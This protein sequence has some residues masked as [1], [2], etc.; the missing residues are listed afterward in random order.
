MIV[1]LKKIEARD[2]DPRKPAQ[3]RGGFSLSAWLRR[4]WAL[5][6]AHLPT[7]WLG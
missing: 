7:T 6:L 5:A 2:E 3:D 1:T 4:W